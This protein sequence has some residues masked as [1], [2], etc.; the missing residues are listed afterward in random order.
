MR[1]WKKYFNEYVPSADLKDETASIRVCQLATYAAELGTYGVGAVILD[2]KGHILIEGHN[3]VFVNDFRSDLH[4]EMVVINK[5]EASY[6]GRHKPGRCTLVTSLEPCPMCMTR[7]I[8][9]GI[10]T[11]LH[12]SEDSMGGM[13][14]R[15]S[16]LPPIFQKITKEQSQIW[17][18]AECS[19]GLREAAFQIWYETDADVTQ[20]IISRGNRRSGDA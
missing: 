8:F 6:Q 11:I 20:R 9:A 1:D 4:A 16:S 19:E 3:E 15:K 18:L 10:G 7:L 13:V 14:Q 17:G 2:D 12:V 5:F